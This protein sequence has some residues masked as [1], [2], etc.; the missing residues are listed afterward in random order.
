MSQKN[1]EVIIGRLATDEEFRLEFQRD[2]S[3]TLRDLVE[4][5]FELTRSEATALSA[6]DATAF[7]RLAASLDPR[8]QK[9]SLKSDSDSQVRT[10]ADRWL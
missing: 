8:L 3:A 1:V 5:G 9:A 10:E 4:H 6:L 7:E 2:P